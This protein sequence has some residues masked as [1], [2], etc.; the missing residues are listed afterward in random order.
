MTSVCPQC[1]QPVLA[2]NTST[3]PV[4]LNP[5]PHQDGTYKVLPQ[6]DRPPFTY[7]PSVARR[8]GLK[9]YNKHVCKKG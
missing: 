2:C 5:E 8:F 6:L 7:Q 9:L 4:L 1:D 3:K